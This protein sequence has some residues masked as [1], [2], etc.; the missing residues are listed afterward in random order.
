MIPAGRAALATSAATGEGIDELAKAIAGRLTQHAAHN[1]AT[2]ASD[3]A[4][5]GLRRAEAALAEAARVHATGAGE[6]LVSLELRA[7]L[8]ALGEVVGDVTSD[9]VLGQVFAR[10]CIGK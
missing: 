7:A 10:F 1:V 2:G 8:G 9:E 5:S 6:E 4:R 3:R